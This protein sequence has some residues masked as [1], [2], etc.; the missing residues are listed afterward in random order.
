MSVRASL[1]GVRSCRDGVSEEDTAEPQPAASSNPESFRW[2]Q[3]RL[4]HGAIET[5]PATD[6]ATTI[7]T[8]P[9]TASPGVHEVAA[10]CPSGRQ[11]ETMFRVIATAQPTLV[12]NPTKGTPGSSTTATVTGLDPCTPYDIAFRWDKTTSPDRPHPHGDGT[13]TLTVPKNATADTYSVTA[14][15]GDATTPPAT[16]RI[17]AA[18][19]PTLTLDPRQGAPG[20]PTTATVTGLAP[21]TPGDITFRWGDTM[22]PPSVPKDD[23][24][25]FTLTVP[26]DAAPADHSVTASCHD[27]TTPPFTFTVLANPKPALS[28][29]PGHGEPGS[30]A[31]ATGSGFACDGDVQLRWDD[32]VLT[33]RLSGAFTQSF[34]VPATAAPTV[35]SVTASCRNDSTINDTQTF[36]VT[37]VPVPEQPKP[38]LTLRPTSGTPDSSVEATGEWFPCANGSGPVN[39]AWD[40]G[41]TLIGA[42]LDQTGSF[43]TSIPVPSNA[44]G[45]RVTLRATCAD[46]VVLA[47][48]FTVLGSSQPPPPPPPSHPW[49]VWLIVGIALAALGYALRRLL[50]PK[51]MH[52]HAVPHSDGAPTV[53]VRESPQPGETTHTLRL[54]PHV[55][56]GTQTVR[57]VDDDQIHAY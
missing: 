54:E 20:S 9:A 22:R 33:E 45:G 57:E 2:D 53:V 4:S 6:S 27:T 44:D 52:I 21:C 56:L 38:T 31:T 18:P 19:Q 29:E 24:G 49:V 5:D 39:L 42:P 55:D 14:S 12:L 16:F 11:A 50:R 7:F 1:N 37:S 34:T 28:L 26:D 15:C 51:P 25:T 35:H 47:A 41:T 8:V 46:G 36:T 23:A 32:T 3:S 48:D 10:Q 43:R 30:E 40:D 13:F 17:D